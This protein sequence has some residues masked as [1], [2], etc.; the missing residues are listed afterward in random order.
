MPI[1]EIWDLT[2]D[3]IDMLIGF[4][5]EAVGIAVARHLLLK[6]FRRFAILSAD[7]PRGLRR[8][9]S[10]I[11]ELKRHGVGDVPMVVLPAPATLQTGR[12]GFVRLLENALPEVIVCSTDT[13][14][15]ESSPRLQSVASRFPAM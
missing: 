4:S 15:Q 1:V 2:D 3:P 6:D 9:A 11:D 14:A 5:H 10:I 7:D 8:S 13:L 12:E